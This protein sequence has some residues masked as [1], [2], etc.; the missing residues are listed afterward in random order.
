MQC[1]VY[2]GYNICIFIFV[3]NRFFQLIESSAISQGSV[4]IGRVATTNK[5][6]TT[7]LLMG[8]GITGSIHSIL[9]HCSPDIFKVQ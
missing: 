2:V 4:D 1:T 7:E 9:S 5:H 3:F 6:D 8:A